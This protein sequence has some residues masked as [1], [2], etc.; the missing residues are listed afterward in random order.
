MTPFGRDRNMCVNVTCNFAVTPRTQGPMGQ[1][2]SV[3]ASSNDSGA[4]GPDP[5]LRQAYVI[6]LND[7]RRNAFV[8]SYR[9]TDLNGT[10]PL[11][12]QEG[13]AARRDWE[14]IQQFT[15]L[16][17]RRIIERNKDG[18][19]RRYHSELPSPGAIGCTLSHALV[20]RDILNTLQSDNEYALVFEDDA[21]IP[22]RALESITNAAE[23]APRGWDVLLLGYICPVRR[24]CPLVT[25]KGTNGWD[26]R[27]FTEFW[28][29]HAYAISK[30]GA[31]KLLYSNTAPIVPVVTQIDAFIGYLAD[32]GKVRVF[33]KHIVGNN[34][35]AAVNSSIQ[36]TGAVA[37]MHRLGMKHGISDEARLEFERALNNDALQTRYLYWLL[38]HRLPTKYPCTPIEAIGGG[39]R[40]RAA[41][42]KRHVGKTTRGARRAPAT[43]V[44]SARTHSSPIASTNTTAIRPQAYTRGNRAAAVAAAAALATAG[45]AVQRNQAQKRAAARLR[46][47]ARAADEATTR[48]QGCEQALS[49]TDNDEDSLGVIEGLL[50]KCAPQSCPSCSDE[51]VAW[52]SEMHS[53]LLVRHEALRPH[54][55]VVWPPSQS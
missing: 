52:M 27:A 18:L 11:I 51:Q 23:R 13:V 34:I 44:R 6:S 14:D 9:A 7:A 50:Q 2:I 35:V 36:I 53:N 33:G 26:G 32:Q 29:T 40:A 45:I 5:I 54:D 42:S 55:A 15:T 16:S 41:T 49:N 21:R 22:A 24:R 28:Q 12:W 47:A 10:C 8:R 31:R 4:G 17:G 46:E 30:Q 43:D 38:H 20:Y 3:D 37:W 19:G 48:L 1:S 25:N 39:A